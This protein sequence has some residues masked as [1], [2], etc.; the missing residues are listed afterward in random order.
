MKE[1][2]IGWTRVLKNGVKEEGTV[3]GVRDFGFDR[4]KIERSRELR[5]FKKK[6]QGFWMGNDEEEATLKV[7]RNKLKSD[8][9]KKEAFYDLLYWNL[10]KKLFFFYFDLFLIKIF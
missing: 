9:N 8:I 3:R 5:S 7:D 6:R 2:W 10:K 4:I 1:R